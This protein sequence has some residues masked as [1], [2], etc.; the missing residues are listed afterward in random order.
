MASQL[1]FI[2]LPIDSATPMTRQRLAIKL[3]SNTEGIQTM[4]SY[5]HA[6]VMCS[7]SNFYSCAIETLRQELVRYGAVVS[8]VA[9]V[10]QK[11]RMEIAIIPKSVISAVPDSKEATTTDTDK[12]TITPTTNNANTD[13][14]SAVNQILTIAYPWHLYSQSSRVTDRTAQRS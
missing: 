2:R 6:E 4:T 11:E 7:M 1:D 9:N 14:P 5:E 13:I 10:A 3:H 8:N 12:P